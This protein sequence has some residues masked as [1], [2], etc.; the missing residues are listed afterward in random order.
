MKDKN[1]EYTNRYIWN[2]FK[3]ST[4]T[5]AGLLFPSISSIS[6]MVANLPVNLQ[7]L[8]IFSLVA[9]VGG[10]YWWHWFY[11]VEELAKLGSLEYL[12]KIDDK[13]S[14]DIVQQYNELERSLKSSKKYHDLQKLLKSNF[15]DFNTTL[16]EQKIIDPN[17]KNRFKNS[18]IQA[19]SKA[20]EI[21]REISDILVV[22]KSID[23]KEIEK[24]SKNDP[25]QQ[26][27]FNK[28]KKSYNE[29]S[30]KL[31]NLT[32]A[33]ETIIHSYTLAIS[34]TALITSKTNLNIESSQEL[35]HAIDVAKEVQKKIS[36]ISENMNYVDNSYIK[37]Y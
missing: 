10:S 19:F 25:N 5:I 26:E 2:R 22:Q 32:S 13:K 17:L 35:E 7:V 18:S 6:M 33:L 23:I 11:N 3:Y 14:V 28:I 29:N 34:N 24:L 12:Q 37:R 8:N 21:L 31:Q 30:D 15:D 1:R 9:M 27:I 36:A 4:L 20:I 16:D